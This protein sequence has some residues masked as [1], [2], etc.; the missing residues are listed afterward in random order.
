MDILHARTGEAKKLL[1]KRFANVDDET[2]SAGFDSN[3]VTTPRSPELT[4][5]IMQKPIDFTNYF[6][7]EPMKM[8]VSAFFTDEIVKLASD[9]LKKK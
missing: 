9:G 4:T 8:P 5:E 1:R 2:Y 7:K 3:L 6:D